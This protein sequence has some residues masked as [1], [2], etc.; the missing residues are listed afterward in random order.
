MKNMAIIGLVILAI[1]L[2]SGCVQE[3]PKTLEKYC[4]NLSLSEAKQIASASECAK[5]GKLKE[6]YVCNEITGTWWIDLNI[7]K[8]GCS[9]ACVINVETKQAEINWRC[10]GLVKPP[11]VLQIS[12]F[13]KINL[14]ESGKI[15]PLNETE[16]LGSI[17]ALTLSRLNLQAKCIY[18]EDKIQQ[19]KN[20][21]KVIEVVFNTL[22]NVTIS[23]RIEPEERYHIPVDENGY[24]ILD[25]V[26]N[27][28]FILE[29]NLDEGLEAHILVGYEAYG[30]WAIKQEGSNELDKSWIGDINRIIKNKEGFCGSSTNGKCSSDSDCLAGGCSGQVCQS[31]NEESIITTC[32]WRDCYSAKKYDLKCKCIDTKCQWSG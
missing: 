8:E 11:E 7:K 13:E 28:L 5:E 23:Q 19:I 15:R 27:V 2:I 22:Q 20:N 24:R 31:K 3:N 12:D 26:K 16:E 17:L 25:N 9:P 1:M 14:Y 32:E 6:T 10:T 4:K 30:C 21:D 29:D 18:K